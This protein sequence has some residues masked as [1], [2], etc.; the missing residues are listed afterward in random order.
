[1]QIIAA[2]TSAVDSIILYQPDAYAAATATMMVCSNTCLYTKLDIGKLSHII[3]NRAI[4][5]KS[6]VTLI[7]GRQL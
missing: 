7:I 2:C 3:Y 5:S 4:S 6:W 1:M